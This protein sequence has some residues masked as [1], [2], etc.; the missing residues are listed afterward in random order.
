M[1]EV[2]GR[3][4]LFN[5]IVKFLKMEG[6]RKIA[7]FGSFARSEDRPDSDI[8]I[9]V[10][11]NGPI[12]LLEFIGI[13]QDLSELIGKKVDMQTE[14][15]ISPYIIDQIRKEMVVVLG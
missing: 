13:E 7:I 3:E 12:S 2:Y 9:L 11:F 8:D 15:S 1:P 14:K 6:A 4:N 10:E 5:A